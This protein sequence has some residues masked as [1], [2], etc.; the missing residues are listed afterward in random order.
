[1]RDKSF[2]CLPTT[3][4]VSYLDVYYEAKSIATMMTISYSVTQFSNKFAKTRAQMLTPI[5]HTHREKNEKNIVTWHFATEAVVA[6]RVRL[7]GTCLY[8]RFHF[9]F[10]CMLN[11][12]A[13][14]GAG[15]HCME[16]RI[17]K[18]AT[19]SRT[20][21]PTVHSTLFATINNIT[22]YNTATIHRIDMENCKF[23]WRQA[24]ASHLCYFMLCYVR[25]VRALWG[26]RQ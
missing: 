22:M 8:F 6:N 5:R 13:D 11:I 4:A 20:P 24:C 25:L 26:S 17:I 19:T 21:N 2:W 15:I 3:C 9:H 10:R 7:I 1:M 14:I 12:L 16:M 23:W 18:Y